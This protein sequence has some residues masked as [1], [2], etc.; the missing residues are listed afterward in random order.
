MFREKLGSTTTNTRRDVNA[1]QRQ[2]LQKLIFGSWEI[3]FSRINF[4]KTAKGW[5]AENIASF[6]PCSLWLKGLNCLRAYRCTEEACG[7][8][9]AVLTKHGPLKIENLLVASRAY[10]TMSDILLH[11]SWTLRNPIWRRSLLKCEAAPVVRP[12][13]QRG[14]ISVYRLEKGK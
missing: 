5:S 11:F 8:L 10:R 6:S 1:S 9:R 12:W 7:D 3:K 13:R 14:F 2:V 4:Y